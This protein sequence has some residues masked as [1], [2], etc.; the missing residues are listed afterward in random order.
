MLLSA[1]ADGS[2]IAWDADSGAQLRRFAAHN[3]SI[4]GAAFGAD[5]HTVYSAAGDGTMMAWDVSGRSDLLSA[6]PAGAPAAGRLGAALAAPNGR[7]VARIQDDQVA[8]SPPTG[9]SSPRPT[10]TDRW[11]CWTPTS[12]PGSASSRGP[13]WG[14][15]VAFAPDGSQFASVQPDRL[16]L[17]DGRTG[18][19][20]ASIPLPGLPA[21]G[22]YSKDILGP[23]ATISLPP[24]QQRPSGGARGR[25][26]LDGEDCQERL[27]GPRLPHRRPQLDSGRVAAALPHPALRGHL[28][29][30]ARGNLSAGRGTQRRS[31]PLEGCVSSRREEL[32][33]RRPAAGS[34]SVD[35]GRPAPRRC[36]WPARARPAAAAAGPR[37]CPGAAALAP[38]R[39]GGPEVTGAAGLGAGGRA[40]S[41]LDRTAGWSPGR[42]RSR[43]PAG[44][45]WS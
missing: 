23:G 15:D 13:S 5:D 21:A 19:Y 26:S 24:R 35:R 32:S 7:T 28:Q 38:G 45:G 40:G 10:K 30:V 2:T 12:P 20:Q 4:W 18:A 8:A 16:R 43:C 44:R 27:V 22:R 42:G 31:A 14:G 37:D 39:A 6:G 41:G 17:W 33:R 34:A 1:S 3:A 25:T 11:V 36:S 29:A 9:H